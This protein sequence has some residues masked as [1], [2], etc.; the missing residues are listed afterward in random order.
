MYPDYDGSNIERAIIQ[1]RNQFED[2]HLAETFKRIKNGDPDTIKNMIPEHVLN[3]I[4]KETRNQLI[5]DLRKKEA[6]RRKLASPQ[7]EKGGLGK[8]PD[9]KPVNQKS[10]RDIR[11]DVLNTMRD[12]NIS[13]FT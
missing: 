11:S 4:K 6:Q 7:P 9:S 3:E 8:V 13:L 5:E 2:V 12:E 1:G 10:Y